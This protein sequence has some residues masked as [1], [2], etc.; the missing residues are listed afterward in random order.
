[1]CEF[2]NWFP[3]TC[4]SLVFG[5]KGA[6]W[7][8][9]IYNYLYFISLCILTKI[10]SKRITMLITRVSCPS[11]VTPSVTMTCYSVT[12]CQVT[13]YIANVC[14]T[15][16]IEALLTYY[17][18][19]LIVVGD[20]RKKKHVLHDISWLFSLRFIKENTTIIGRRCKSYRYALKKLRITFV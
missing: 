11:W 15:K 12:A 8:Q 3:C 4:T 19:P 9:C 20:L 17:N 5:K 16:T 13:V 14:T 10:E 2:Y 1:M 6:C 18:N 7:E